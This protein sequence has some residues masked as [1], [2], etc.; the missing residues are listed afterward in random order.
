MIQLRKLV[1]SFIIIY[2]FLGLPISFFWFG[3]CKWSPLNAWV[4]WKKKGIWGSQSW[5]P[6]PWL[7]SPRL[8]RTPSF[9][10]ASHRRP[11]AASP[12]LSC[13]CSAPGKTSWV[14][15]TLPSQTPAS[16]SLKVN[17]CPKLRTGRAF[18][19]IYSKVVI[20]MQKL[21]H[22]TCHLFQSGHYAALY[23]PPEP[24]SPAP[25]FCLTLPILPCETS[26]HHKQTPVRLHHFPRMLCF[27]LIHLI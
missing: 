16:A 22:L 12:S 5:K 24:S 15:Q 4:N 2:T 21:L 13:C 9:Q 19:F 3:W 14:G 20:K 10:S 27:L 6:W 26:F 17:F 11:V 25:Y 23:L 8:L 7:P 18:H 1:V